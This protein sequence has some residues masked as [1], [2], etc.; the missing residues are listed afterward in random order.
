M[1]TV[2]VSANMTMTLFVK[3]NFVAVEGIQNN[4]FLL[5]RDKVVQLHKG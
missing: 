4:S 5:R 2:A 3:A 1:V